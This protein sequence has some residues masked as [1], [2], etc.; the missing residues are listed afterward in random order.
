MSALSLIKCLETGCLQRL[1][2]SGHQAMGF[3][4]WAGFGEPP[5][6]QVSCSSPSPLCTGSCG[7]HA[8]LPVHCALSPVGTPLFSLAAVFRMDPLEDHSRASSMPGTALPPGY[9]PNPPLFYSSSL[10]RVCEVH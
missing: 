3:E 8:A 5:G 6:E 4:K 10:Q 1:A 9:P 2:V 7:S